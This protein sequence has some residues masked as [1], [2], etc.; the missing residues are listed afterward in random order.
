MINNVTVT[1]QPGFEN[2]PDRVDAEYHITF[3]P[4]TSTGSISSISGGIGSSTGFLLTDLSPNN[5][6]LSTS[7]E[8]SVNSGFNLQL[9]VSMFISLT[10]SGPDEKI[11]TF[12]V[13]LGGSPVLVLPE[14]YVANSEDGLIVNSFYTGPV[15]EPSSA[16]MLLSGGL[17][18]QWRRRR[19]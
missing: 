15:P 8:I 17:F 13:S 18:M 1:K 11:G 16:A 5:L 10:G 19:A 3:S 9:A 4:D 2:L 7:K 12:S 6:T 14:G